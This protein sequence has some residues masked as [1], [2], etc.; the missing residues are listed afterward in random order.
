M[1]TT[2]LL[3]V[4]PAVVPAAGWAAHAL[5][6]ARRLRTVRTDPLT[7]LMCRDEFTGRARRAVRH[8]DAA[9]LLLDLDDFKSINDTY[10]H[11]AGDQALAAVGTRLEAW[12]RE[13]HDFAARLG[14]DEF[15]AVVR[16][17]ENADLQ[18]ELLFGLRA[19]LGE[20]VITTTGALLYPSASIG[21]C[22]AL[23]RPDAGLPEL[24]RGADEAMYT[25]RERIGL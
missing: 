2:T 3:H 11:A 19:R 25:A 7:T 23:Q 9:V 21:V 5:Y 20:A 15:A 24:L 6:L 13:R 14:G 8:P 1:T 18:A 16:L 17:A 4:L 10:G 12:C 22:R